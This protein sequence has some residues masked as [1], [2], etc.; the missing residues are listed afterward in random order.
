MGLH[1][2][3]PYRSQ[4]VRSEN[5]VADNKRETARGMLADA[6][7]LLAAMPEEAKS[8]YF[9][10]LEAMRPEAPGEHRLTVE[11]CDNRQSDMREWLQARIDVEEKRVARLR[12]SII[13]AMRRYKNE[14]PVE[15]SEVDVSVEAAGEYRVMLE[16]LRA[17]DLPRFE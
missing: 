15:T 5:A 4:R 16:Q 6:R 8:H 13:D 12:E 10:K 1:M 3:T 7:T 14:W 9:P 17:D 2:F 11:S